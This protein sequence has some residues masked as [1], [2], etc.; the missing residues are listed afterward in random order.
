MLNKTKG[1][2]GIYTQSSKFHYPVNI[3]TA[4]EQILF[5][6]TRQEPQSSRLLSSQVFRSNREE[7]EEDANLVDSDEELNDEKNRKILMSSKLYSEGKS[8]IVLNF[9]EQA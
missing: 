4:E 8:A 6:V 3:P 2:G 9:K 7:T 1:F 5:Q